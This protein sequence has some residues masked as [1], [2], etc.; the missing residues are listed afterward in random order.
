MTRKRYEG[1]PHYMDA[2]FTQIQR[3][4]L[5]WKISIKMFTPIKKKRVDPIFTLDE[6]KGVNLC[7]S[8]VLYPIS[9][10]EL[11]LLTGL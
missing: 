2:K 7:A 10:D 11:A 9:A 8:A 6:R 4:V 5:F 1:T 3:E